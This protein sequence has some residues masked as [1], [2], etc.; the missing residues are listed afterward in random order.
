MRHRARRGRAVYRPPDRAADYAAARDRHCQ[1]P[2]CRTPASRC[3]LDHRHPYHDDGATCPCNTDLLCRAHH[4]AKTFTAWHAKPGPDGLLLWA[5]PTG[6]TYPKE[7]SH[8]LTDR[9]ADP[10]PF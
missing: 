8:L 4:R 9:A 2:G 5:S 10:P 6:H 1:W 3:D 7:P